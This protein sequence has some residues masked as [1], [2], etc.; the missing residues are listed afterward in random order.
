MFQLKLENHSK[1]LR[2]LPLKLL[3]SIVRLFATHWMKDNKKE[4]KL[5]NR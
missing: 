1:A 2:M 5:K 3:D 4:S